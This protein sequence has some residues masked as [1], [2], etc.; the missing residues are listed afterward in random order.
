VRSTFGTSGAI[1]AAG[2]LT[3]LL[4]G[5]ASAEQPEVQ[6]VATRFEDSSGEARARCDLLA[7]RTLEKLEEQL[8]EPCVEGI[9]DLPLEGGDVGQVEVWGGNAQV[10]LGG[11]TVFLTRTATGWRVTAAVCSPRAQGPYD[12]EV[13]S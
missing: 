10:Q 1:L 4:T 6:R 3:V 11:D 8:A 5:C 12:C 2:A 7:P 13:E 9:G